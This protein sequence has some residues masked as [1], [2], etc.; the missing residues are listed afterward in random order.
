MYTYR[1]SVK[2]NFADIE[3]TITRKGTMASRDL[4][5]VAEAFVSRD[6]MKDAAIESRRRGYRI[7]LPGKFVAEC[8][9]ID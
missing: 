8:E 7:C 9:L 3:G 6:D 4:I 1:I 5:S 2:S